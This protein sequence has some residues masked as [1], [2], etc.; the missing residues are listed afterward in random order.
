MGMF[1]APSYI[2]RQEGK[3]DQLFFGQ[4]E[5]LTRGRNE[6]G[7]FVNTYQDGFCEHESTDF[8]ETFQ[9]TSYELT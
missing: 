9:V 1:G 3:D 6:I 4:G 2:L 8:C 7:V 5:Y